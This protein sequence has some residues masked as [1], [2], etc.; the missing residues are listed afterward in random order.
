MNGKQS[1]YQEKINEVINKNNGIITTADFIKNEIPRI[2][3]TKMVRDGFLTRV[4]RGIY[5]SNDADYDEYYFFQ[6]TYK[7]CLYSYSSSLFLHDLI[8]KVPE[9]KEI[10]VPNN[11]NVKFQDQEVVIHYVKKRHFAV[12]RT[13]VKTMFGNPVST[14]NKERTI[15]D[16]IKNRK[17]VDPEIFVKAL[18]NYMR[19]KKKN[20]NRLMEYAKLFNIEEKVTNLLEV[21]YG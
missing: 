9:I 14:Y 10:T 16:L 2:Y 19:N 11:Y 18:N 3:L 15:C 21:L 12:G 17:D 6:L 8:D 7:K 5:L 4:G 13:E 20:I 1:I